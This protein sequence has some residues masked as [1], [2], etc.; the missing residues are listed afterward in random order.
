MSVAGLVGRLA[1][2]GPATEP[3]TMSSIVVPIHLSQQPFQ[4]HQF[5]LYKCK[6]YKYVIS[7]YLIYF[8]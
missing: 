8:K 3:P 4:T 6:N 7:V 5:I 1:D 2:F